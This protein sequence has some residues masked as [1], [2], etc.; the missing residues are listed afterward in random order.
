[1]TVGRRMSHIA[2]HQSGQ[3]TITCV[4]R[5]CILIGKDI[6]R[7]T[8]ALW[9]GDRRTRLHGYAVVKPL[10]AL[11]VDAQARGQLKIKKKN[12]NKIVRDLTITQLCAGC[13]CTCKTVTWNKERVTGLLMA[14]LLYIT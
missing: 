12:E 11:D 1:M 9:E 13:G 10:G 7:H 5:S 6:W 14:Q 2:T 8:N 3:Y 4:L